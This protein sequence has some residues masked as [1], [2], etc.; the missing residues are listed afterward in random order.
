[1]FHISRL[2]LEGDVGHFLS[3]FECGTIEYYLLPDEL[4]EISSGQLILGLCLNFSVNEN[5][6]EPLNLISRQFDA[7]FQ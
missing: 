2:A 3:R 4:L 1:M 7:L 6:N 5:V